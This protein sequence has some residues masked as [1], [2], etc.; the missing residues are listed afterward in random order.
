ML[1]G[2]VF[3]LMDRRNGIRLFVV[4]DDRIETISAT[5]IRYISRE[6][7]AWRRQT[8]Q[9]AHGT[10]PMLTVVSILLVLVLNKLGHVLHTWHKEVGRNGEGSV[11]T[12][13]D[14][15]RLR[16]K[17]GLVY[18]RG[19]LLSHGSII[20]GLAVR[21]FAS[22]ACRLEHRLVDFR[23]DWRILISLHHRHVVPLGRAVAHI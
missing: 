19:S 15:R 16:Y 22:G 9:T 14:M 10:L 5:H 6:L 4:D 7:L 11:L 13:V 8:H 20:V 2:H 23:L 3:L 21:L 12:L 18:R 17:Q 1:R